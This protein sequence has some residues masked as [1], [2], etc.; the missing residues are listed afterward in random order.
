MCVKIQ[1]ESAIL[2]SLTSCYGY[3][4]CGYLY[5]NMLDQLW[6]FGCTQIIRKFSIYFFFV[7]LKKKR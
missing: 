2:S 4:R 6:M 1:G 7:C 5:D 3:R